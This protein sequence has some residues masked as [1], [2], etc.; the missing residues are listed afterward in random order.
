MILDVPYYEKVLDDNKEFNPY[1][2]AYHV[3]FYIVNI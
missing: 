1:E 3:F 2:R